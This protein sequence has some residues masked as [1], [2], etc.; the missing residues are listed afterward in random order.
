MV[1]GV[2]LCEN[3]QMVAG[4][5]QSHLALSPRSSDSS[6]L[7]STIPP[8]HVVCSWECFDRWAWTFVSRGHAP[9]MIGQAYVLGGVRLHPAT[10]GRAVAMAD[11]RRRGQLLEPARH[12]TQAAVDEPVLRLFDQR[13]RIRCHR[14][15]IRGIV[16]CG[17]PR[18]EPVRSVVREDPD[19]PVGVRNDPCP[20]DPE[21]EFPTE[22][23]DSTSPSVEP[24]GYL[25]FSDR[26]HPELRDRVHENPLRRTVPRLHEDSG[27]PQF[28]SISRRDR[29]ID[30]V[31][32]GTPRVD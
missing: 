9:V 8:Y 29:D 7:Y 11:A 24:F 2:V 32:S 22:G 28:E 30:D 20:V 4:Y 27:T 5:A 26:V 21:A 15:P 1:C 14:L 10:A 25:P 23:K 12:L 19:E 18:F 17:I 13:R 6:L 31:R 16:V 3:C